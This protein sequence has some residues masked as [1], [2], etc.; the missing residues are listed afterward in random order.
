[1]ATRTKVEIKYLESNRTETEAIKLGSIP[2]SGY[3]T[4]GYRP[5]A[6]AKTSWQTNVKIILTRD[7][8][9]YLYDLLT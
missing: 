8:T 6:M 5:R 4:A 2:I 9:L 1:M 7:L 3:N